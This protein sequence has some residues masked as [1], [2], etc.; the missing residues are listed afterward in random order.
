MLLGGLAFFGDEIHKADHLLVCQMHLGIV[1]GP[2]YRD[3]GEKSPFPYTQ[4]LQLLVD[5]FHL[6]Y[7]AAVD[8]A[9]NVKVQSSFLCGNLYGFDRVL[10]TVGIAPHPVMVFSYSVKAE[11]Y[12][13]EAGCH[14]FAVHL[15]RVE[16][17]VGN[18][19][20]VVSSLGYLFADLFYV[21]PE[22]RLSAGQ[23]NYQSVY[24]VFAGGAAGA[25]IRLVEFN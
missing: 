9:Y 16:E 24:I 6:A 20:P 4:R 17:T 10:V 3:D 11:R 12:G 15:F 8:A 22:K 21:R 19:A 23:D 18:H 5:F 25:G 2:A 1:F 13:L 7:A 14:E